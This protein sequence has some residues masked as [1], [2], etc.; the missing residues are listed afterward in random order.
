M[1]VKYLFSDD[2]LIILNLFQTQTQLQKLQYL[3]NRV[4]ESF[5]GGKPLHLL[6]NHSSKLNII[7]EQNW[8]GMSSTH[9]Q[10]RLKMGPIIIKNSGPSSFNFDLELFADM[11]GHGNMH[12]VVLMEGEGFL[13]IEM[14]HF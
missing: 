4:Q 3:H 6:G 9:A 14:G 11:L 7:T 1:Y 2:P 8:S 10:E 12:Y 5:E 13:Q